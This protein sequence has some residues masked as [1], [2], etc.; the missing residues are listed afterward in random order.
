LRLQRQVTAGI[1]HF[2]VLQ[3]AFHSGRNDRTQR[4]RI[5]LRHLYQRQHLAAHNLGQKRKAP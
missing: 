2:L 5:S 1:F 3:A 4:R